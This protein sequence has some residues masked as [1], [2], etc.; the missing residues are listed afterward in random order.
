MQNTPLQRA[1]AANAAIGEVLK[2]IGRSP[3]ILEDM[4]DTLLSNALMLC[5][6]ELG[7]LFLFTPEHSYHAVR[8]KALPP[9]FQQWLTQA[10]HFKANAETGLG[11]IAVQK[12]FVHIHD[13]RSEDI[14]LK[15]DPL[16]IATADLGQARTFRLQ[17]P[18][19]R[20]MSLRVHSR[21]IDGP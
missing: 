18:C 1:L 3:V 8:S 9:E 20:A 13:V 6:A 11:R 21:S 16:R 7:I 5:D 4:F 15:G 17:F 14:Y 2:I 12:K 19:L 10:G